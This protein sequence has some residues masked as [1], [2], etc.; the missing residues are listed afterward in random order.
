MDVDGVHVEVTGDSAETVVLLHGFSDNASTWHRVVPAL[1][2]Q[3][4][5]LAL[6]LPGHGRSTRPWTAPL[7]GGYADIVA[8]VLD[9][10]GIDDPV[11]VVGN[12]MGGCVAAMFAGRYPERTDRIALIGM[13]GLSAVPM[14]WRAA[15][16]RPAVTALRVGLAPVPAAV[17]QRGFGW[18]YAHAASPRP[19]TIDP[20]AVRGYCDVYRDKQRLFGLGAIARQLLREL[21]ALRLDRVLAGCDVPVLQLWGRHDRLVPSRHARGRRGS[22]VL[23]GCGH[24][25]QLDAPDRL[26][27]TLLP[28]LALPAATSRGARSGDVMRAAGS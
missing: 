16:A 24:C 28:F 26:L 25:P 18:I 21:G 4:R 2:T 14:A 23:D 6:D 7:V 10:I 15:A 3:Y 1:A 8:E 13:P 12:S 17:L 19:G 11:R 22:V 5:V 20:R 27:A 9:E